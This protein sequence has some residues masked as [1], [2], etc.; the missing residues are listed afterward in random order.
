MSVFNLLGKKYHSLSLAL[1]TCLESVSLLLLRLVVA[2]VFLMSGLTK[3]DGLFQFNTE[4]YDLFLYEFF[5]PD[6]VRPGALQLCSPDTLDYV[7]GSMT[8]SVVKLFA[9]T[10]GVLEVIL[11]TL[12][13]IGL[14][15]RFAALGL[16][17][18]TLF[19][20][21]AVFPGWD[22]WWNPAAWW[23]ISL[24]AILAIGPGSWSADRLLRI[25]GLVSKPI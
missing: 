13:I 15:S 11:P 21:L 24:L 17:A 22:H 20:Q 12:L 6:P 7:E 1:S 18:M 2:R 8:V 16:L 14:F 9:I 4:K 23:A 10:A 25:D 5:C 19:I 3:W